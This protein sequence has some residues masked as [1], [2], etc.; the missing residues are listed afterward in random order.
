MILKTPNIFFQV[1]GLIEALKADPTVCTNYLRDYV[2]KTYPALQNFKGGNA[3]F[4]FPNTPV[5]C[6]GAPQKIM[7]LADDYF[8]K[9][10]D[11]TISIQL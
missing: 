2:E 3:I 10:R 9:V 7:Y 1:D 4:T 8:R 11:K 5:K 6:A